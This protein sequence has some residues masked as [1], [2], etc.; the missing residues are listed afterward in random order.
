METGL[1]PPAALNITNSTGAT[2][3]PPSPPSYPSP[4]TRFLFEFKRRA[5]ATSFRSVS[6]FLKDLFVMVSAMAESWAKGMY[7]GGGS[8]KRS[9]EQQ[10]SLFLP[11]IGIYMTKRSQD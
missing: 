9:R 8:W 5:S 10:V 3:F 7:F 2:A 1:L 4:P 6:S 11:W